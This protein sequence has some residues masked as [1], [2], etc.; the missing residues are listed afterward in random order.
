M[1]G[2]SLQPL[3]RRSSRT[4]PA[5]AAGALDPVGQ[6]PRCTLPALPGLGALSGAA[7]GAFGVAVSEK[8]AVD[9]PGVPS[10]VPSLFPVSGQSFHRVPR[11][12]C[13]RRVRHE[14]YFLY[15]FLA[16]R[17]HWEQWELDSNE[18]ASA[19]GAVEQTWNDREQMPVEVNPSCQSRIANLSSRPYRF[20]SPNPCAKFLELSWE[21]ITDGNREAV[22]I[23]DVAKLLLESAKRDRLDFRFEA[24]ELQQSPSLSAHSRRGARGD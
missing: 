19:S 1:G 6:E 17:E 20:G 8:G 3:D 23:S 14:R 5:K 24:A 10:V 16:I 7:G 9:V 2:G 18:R 12:P 13:F 11:V 22:S 15:S 4:V 21:F